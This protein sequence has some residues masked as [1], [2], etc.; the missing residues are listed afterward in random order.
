MPLFVV[1]L[2]FLLRY[3]HKKQQV[4]TLWFPTYA[5]FDVVGRKIVRLMVSYNYFK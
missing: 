5:S 1:P 3:S 4:K 2:A